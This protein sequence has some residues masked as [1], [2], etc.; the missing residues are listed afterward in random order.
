MLLCSEVGKCN[1]Q[2]DR[3]RGEN[4]AVARCKRTMVQ[5]GNARL[6]SSGFITVS[7]AD[8]EGVEKAEDDKPPGILAQAN[9]RE[10][11]NPT[12][13]AWPSKRAASV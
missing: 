10:R 6:T 11:K 5:R 12:E 9:G 4:S 1:G 7:K 13:H 3:S 2:E 8:L